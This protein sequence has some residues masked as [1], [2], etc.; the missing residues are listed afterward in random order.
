MN[1]TPISLRSRRHLQQGAAVIELA[2]TMMVFL[3]VA[4]GIM[5]LGR[6]MYLWNTVQEVTRRAAREA[7]VRDFTSQVS[8]IQRE[9]IFR[10]GST[11]AAYLPAGLEI[12]NTRVQINYLNASLNEASPLP[13]DPADNLSACGDASRTSSCIRFVEACVATNSTCTGAVT[14]APMAGLFP[15]LAVSIPVSSV[16]MPAESL[17]FSTAP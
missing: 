13:A 14:Y 2:L 6:I 7:V 1:K 8:A 15:F 9:A 4:L 12:S 5:E 11:G 17:G 3:T 16:V 10:A